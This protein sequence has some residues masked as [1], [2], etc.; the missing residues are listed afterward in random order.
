[1]ANNAAVTDGEA[2][3]HTPWLHRVYRWRFAVSLLRLGA[4]AAVMP[5]HSAEQH[6]G[7]GALPASG[8]ARAE[9]PRSQHYFLRKSVKLRFL[10]H[11]RHRAE[12]AGAE[13]PSS[14]AE[15]R[16]GPMAHR[17]R[18]CE[19]KPGSLGRP[20]LERQ[21]GVAALARFPVKLRCS[22]Q[23]TDDARLGFFARLFRVSADAWRRITRTFERR[24]ATSGSAAR[25]D[26]PLTS[27]ARTP[28][29]G[30]GERQQRARVGRQ[31]W[32]GGRRPT[33][34]ISRPAGLWGAL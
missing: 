25:S 34:A 29:F 14:F 1:M 22:R 20:L 6:F 3:R 15:L 19:A 10:P 7:V 24:A 32:R 11:D 2:E 27:S 26:A 28:R 31:G 30:G 4:T 12:Q 9:L 21:R 16:D 23:R 33:N 18:R 5:R 13:S 17:V 8:E